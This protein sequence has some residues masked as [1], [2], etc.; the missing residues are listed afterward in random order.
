MWRQK[1]FTLRRKSGKKQHRLEYHKSEESCLKG[2]H[3]TIIPL[4]SLIAIELATSKTHEHVFK[5]VF[6]DGIKSLFFSTHNENEMKEWI[7]IIRKLIFPEP[8]AI[9]VT[10]GTSPEGRSPLFISF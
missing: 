7:R 6:R 2:K 9:P 3:T 10:H 1:W 4:Q 8:K 5:L